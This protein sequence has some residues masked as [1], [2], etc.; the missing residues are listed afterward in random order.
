[1]GKGVDRWEECSKH[2]LEA[3][4]KDKN[5]DGT[6]KQETMPYLMRDLMANCVDF[7]EEILA[8][9]YLIEQLSSKGTNKISLIDMPKCL[10]HFYS[11]N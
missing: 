9:Q 1:M 2:K 7:Q 11:L 5:D 4:A 3:T 6:I 10:M 8:M